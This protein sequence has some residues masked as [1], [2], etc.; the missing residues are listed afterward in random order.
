MHNTKILLIT[1]PLYFFG[2]NNLLFLSIFEVK[3]K[4][5]Y[6]LQN[7][8]AFRFFSSFNFIKFAFR[9]LDT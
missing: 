9:K 3:A 2:N 7:W 4:H 6:E 5:F 8:C 1:I